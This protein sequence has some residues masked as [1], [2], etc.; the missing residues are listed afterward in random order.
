MNW[1]E[2]YT[3]IFLKQ[4]DISVNPNTLKEYLP[5]WWKNN[6][7]K[8]VGG[9]RLTNDGLTFLQKKL[10]LKTYEVPFPID[11][12]VTTQA[13]IFL[14]RFINCPYYLA[15]DGLILTQEKKAMELMLFSGDIRKYGISKA[16]TRL[17][18]NED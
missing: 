18:N 8:N 17:A 5:L 16:M 3:K 1:K 9:L 12:R 7:S 10:Q 14:D 2:T 11:F 13:I 4:A 6:R 15:D